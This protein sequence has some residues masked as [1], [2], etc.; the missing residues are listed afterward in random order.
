MRTMILDLSFKVT[1]VGLMW[2]PSM[3]RWMGCYMTGALYLRASLHSTLSYFSS[4]LLF[5]LSIQF[6][7]I[8]YHL[9]G[10][11]PGCLS[12]KEPLLSMLMLNVFLSRYMSPNLLTCVLDRRRLLRLQYDGPM[13]WVPCII[14]YMESVNLV[15]TRLGYCVYIYICYFFVYM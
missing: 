5:I 15:W 10:W 9:D 1:S 11:N 4:F 13:A 12:G 8:L 6:I 2:L 3:V 14:I 7:I